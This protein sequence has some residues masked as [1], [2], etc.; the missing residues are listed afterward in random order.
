MA[1][2][3]SSRK[4]IIAQYVGGTKAGA[5]AGSSHTGAMAG[6]DYVYDDLFEQAGII[7]VDSIEEVCRTGWV[8]ASQPPLEGKR[9]AVLTN[10]GGPGTGIATTCERYGLD[11]PEFSD[12]IQEE[13]GRHIAGHASARNPVDL[14]FHLDM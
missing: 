12:K 4:P 10:S 13:I 1:R 8:L 6:P 14:T 7:R 2:K 3:I 11:V 9:I 5:R